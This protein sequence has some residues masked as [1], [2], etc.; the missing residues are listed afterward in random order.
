[1][2]YYFFL[3]DRYRM[4]DI[5]R[6]DTYFISKIIRNIT[7]SFKTPFF[8]SLT[9]KNH[10]QAEYI[11]KHIYTKMSYKHIQIGREIENVRCIE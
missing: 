6:E 5:T 4:L 8:L 3:I 11:K 10:I 1:M 2:S 9:L 7:S